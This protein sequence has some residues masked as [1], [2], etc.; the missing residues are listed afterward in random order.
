[1]FRASKVFAKHEWN[2]GFQNQYHI[3]L[4]RCCTSVIPAHRIWNSEDQKFKPTLDCITSLRPAWHIWDHV[5][6]YCYVFRVLTRMLRAEKGMGKWG[7]SPQYLQ[8]G[9]AE[10]EPHPGD[11][12]RG[13]QQLLS[14]KQS[15]GT[16]LVNLITIDPQDQLTVR[17]VCG[18]YLGAE[19]FGS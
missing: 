7:I 13:Q 19:L 8:S 17:E 14:W 11:F 10:L 2:S 3:N 1:M 6:K 5:K 15:S 9:R 18:S 16:L 12:F 4:A